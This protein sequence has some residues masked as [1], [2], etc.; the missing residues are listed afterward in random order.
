MKT[1]AELIGGKEGEILSVEG[2]EDSYSYSTPDA[3][4]AIET[5]AKSQG[6]GEDSNEMTPP[7][8]EAGVE[9]EPMS[10]AEAEADPVT[11]DKRVPPDGIEEGNTAQPPP[12]Q[13]RRWCE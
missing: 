4:S 5:E 1:H 2:S 7:A 12:S 13:C 9:Q 11:V 8:K 10:D 3:E 6:T